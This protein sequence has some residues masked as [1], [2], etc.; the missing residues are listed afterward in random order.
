MLGG[1]GFRLHCINTFA[2]RINPPPLTIAL[3]RDSF[4]YPVPQIAAIIA[5]RKSTYPAVKTG[6]VV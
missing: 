6:S 5:G 3:V 2:A 4:A 1:W